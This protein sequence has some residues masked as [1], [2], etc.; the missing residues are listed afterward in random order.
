MPGTQ[1]GWIELGQAI[2]EAPQPGKFRVEREAAVVRD[3]AVVFVEAESS[4]LK[5]MSREIGFDVFLGYRFVLRILCLGSKDCGWEIQRQQDEA[6][7][8]AFC[9]KL[10]QTAD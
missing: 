10:P 5:R 3:F 7:G 4:S 1:F 9:G 8:E 2:I 6:K